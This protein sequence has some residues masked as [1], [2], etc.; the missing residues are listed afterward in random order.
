KTRGA[1]AAAPPARA[2]WSG[3]GRALPSPRSKER[4]QLPEPA[5]VQREAELPAQADTT[6]RRRRAGR[7]GT[8]E[9]RGAGGSPP[10][11]DGA[12]PAART[13]GRSAR[14]RTARARRHE[15]PPPRRLRRGHGGAARVERFPPRERWSESTGPNAR[16][17]SAQPSCPRNQ[18]QLERNV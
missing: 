15:E 17:F 12:R 4:V 16:A 6:S 14:S 13:S 10:A 7:A 18:D 2:R 3:S 9:R 8:V 1:A 5:G 11:S